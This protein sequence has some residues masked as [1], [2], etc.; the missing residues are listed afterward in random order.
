MACHWQEENMFRR[1]SCHFYVAATDMDAAREYVPAM[2]R[3]LEGKDGRVYLDAAR[4]RV[5]IRGNEAD[6]YP[7]LP[8]D[9]WFPFLE[10]RAAADDLRGGKRFNPDS[11][12]RKI[13]AQLDTLQVRER[14]A[15]E[16]SLESRWR[17]VFCSRG[18]LCV[19]ASVC[20]RVC[21]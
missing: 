3:L 4:P 1:S 20:V 5:C 11:M 8:R 17:L 19:Y 9:A 13:E 21:M 2:T 10:L 15:V 18:C 7:W 12:R 6:G 16:T 14:M